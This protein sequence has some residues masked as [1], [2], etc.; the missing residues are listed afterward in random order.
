MAIIEPVRTD[1]EHPHQIKKN[2]AS[3]RLWHWAS[4]IAISGSLIT[5]LINATITDEHKTPSFFKDE[6]QKSGASISDDQAR[7][8]AGALSD[9]VWSVHIYFGYCLAGLLLFRLVLEFFQLADQK[10]IRKIK[11]AYIQFNTIKKNRQLATHELTVKIIYALFYVL[12][13]IMVLTGLSLAFESIAFLKPFRHTIKRIH[14]LGM[15]FVLA[16]IIVHLAGVFLAEF[17]KDGKGIVSAMINGGGEE[18]AS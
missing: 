16:F 7:S 4:M 11:S 15:Y 2:S 14:N 1:I 17:R 3:L 13:T 5:V 10:F 12:L 9:R 8:V 6:L 18:V